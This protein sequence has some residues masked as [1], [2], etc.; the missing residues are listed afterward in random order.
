[1][2]SVKN[3][4]IPANEQERLSNLKSVQILDT[5]PEK[6]Y[7]ALTQLA[8]YICGTPIALVSL[9]DEKRQWFKSSVGLGAPETPRDISFCQHAIM[10]HSIFEVKNALD[11]PRFA[12][13][14]LVTGNPDIRFYAG[15]PLEFAD[16]INLG[17]LCVIDTVPRELNEEQKNALSLLA[18]QVVNLLKHRKDNIELNKSQK[19]FSNFFDLSL[20]LMCIANLDGTFNK[21]SPSF[22]HVL[23]YEVSELEGVEFANF[24]HPEDIESTFN[25]VEKLSQGETLINF[26][27]RFQKKDGDYIILSWNC[28]PD[29]T[30][31]ELYAIARDVTL[32]K[33]IKA[34]LEGTIEDIKLAQKDLRDIN[35]AINEST[36]VSK[37]DAKG[38]I[39]YAN[40]KFCEI[41]KYNVFELIGSDHRILNSGYHSKE[42]FRDLWQTIS[43]GLI[44][45][46]EIK[47]KAKDGSYYWVESTIVPFL[48][49]NGNLK[50]YISIRNDITEIK[51]A[52][53]ILEQ[54]S[55]EITNY[56]N[57]INRSNATVEFDLNGNILSVNNIFCSLFGYDLDEILSKNHQQ[58]VC[59][60][61][62]EEYQLFWSKLRRGEFIS[63]E[64]L[65][66]NKFG[67]NVWIIGNYN[68]IFDLDGNVFKI[69]KIANDITFTKQQ[70]IE[71]DRKNKELDQFA[72]VVSHDLKA[73]LRAINNLA[74][75]IVEDMPDMPEDVEK[76]IYNF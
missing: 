1:M 32:D 36:L 75:W 35:L 45:K 17:T 54:K 73:P 8:S 44:W 28:A 14:P 11:D 4:P 18:V 6:D 29:P 66:K 23:G 76:K 3:S 37:A 68:P 71:L 64:F 55:I 19:T 59:D 38:R 21:V 61:N 22:S 51:N 5:L 41:S 39:T 56:L 10:G 42:F 50:E 26:E 12:N 74:E 63:G 72:Y 34:E 47:N 31:G 9:L 57:S 40:G 60:T 49:T 70:Q 58:F 16:G 65:R 7:D 67:E 43:N 27:N 46:G 33:A 13:N 48:D 2:N 53:R 24:I 69:L 20:D 62:S 30:S 52:Q 25:I 15:V